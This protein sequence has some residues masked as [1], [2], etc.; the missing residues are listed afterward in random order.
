[1]FRKIFKAENKE[2]IL[3]ELPSEYLNKQVEIIAFQISHDEDVTTEKTDLDEAV[4][5][6]DRIHADMSNFKFNRDE[7]NER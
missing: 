2:N 3:V 1:M 7:A 6:F 4:K 5:F